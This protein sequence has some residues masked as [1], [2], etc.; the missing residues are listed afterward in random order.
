VSDVDEIRARHER[1]PADRP[2]ELAESDRAD[3]LTEIDRLRAD[4]L[5]YRAMAPTIEHAERIRDEARRERDRWREHL[6]YIASLPESEGDHAV[7]YAAAVLEGKA[8]H[9]SGT[10]DDEKDGGEHG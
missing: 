8:A 5:R 10:L 9:L 4:L 7:R 3:L 1:I 2:L 6:V